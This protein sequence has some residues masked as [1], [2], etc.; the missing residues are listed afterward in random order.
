MKLVTYTLNED[1]TIPVSVLDGGYVPIANNL[2]S[3]Q[4]VTLV[5]Y[6]EDDYDA[7]TFNSVEEL[8]QYMESNNYV[9]IHPFTE[10]PLSLEVVAQEIWAKG[11]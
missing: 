3:P 2:E 11:A 5:G 9:V 10:L 6:A 7:R 1:G 4:D 8:L